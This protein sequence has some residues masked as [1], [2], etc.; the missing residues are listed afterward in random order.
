MNRHVVTTPPD[1]AQIIAIHKGLFGGWK[2]QA[3][4]APGDGAQ[5][6]PEVGDAKAAPPT[7]WEVKA[8]EWEAKAKQNA[9][10]AKKLAA[11]EDANK[12]ETQRLTDRV[13]A[14]ETSAA[15]WRGKYQSLVAKQAIFDAASSANS[16]DPE[17]VYLYL[18][19]QV[20]VADDG[21]ATGIDAA[22]KQLQQ[23]KPPLFREAPAGARDTLGGK[24][25]APAL[26]SPELEK[27]LRRAV[28]A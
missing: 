23:R 11:L 22:L 6:A 13:T 28:G 2:M 12:S 25:S 20:T 21:T 15:D 5:E 26:N 14:A 10:A 24:P 9:S 27:V 16:A 1:L 4:A 18:R 7:D 8:R 17:T 3:D 19:D